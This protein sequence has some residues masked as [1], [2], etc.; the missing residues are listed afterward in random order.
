MTNVAT[1][2]AFFGEDPYT[3]TDTKTV[4]ADQKPSVSLVKS[5]TP[6]TYDQVG[7]LI[8]YTY[9]LTNTGNVTLTDP[10]IADDKATVSYT[11][12]D[13]NA[14]TKP[15]SL[16]PGAKLYGKATYT[17]AQADLDLGA[18]TN[19]ATGK[20][21]FGEDPYTA[22]DTK[23]VNA[24]QMPA[25]SLVKTAT[26]STYDQVGDLISYTYVLTNTGNVTLTRPFDINDD[27]VLDANLTIPAT[28]VSLA[29]NASITITGTYE[30]TADDL[31]AGKVTNVATGT[32]KFG[33]DKVTSNEATATIIAVG[34]LKVFKYYDADHS[35][36]YT[37]GEVG[38][39][40]WKIR[41]YSASRMARWV[42]STRAPHRVRRL[43]DLH[44]RPGR[45]VLGR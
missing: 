3:A 6:S 10:T 37:P 38:I 17:I 40:G 43:L 45:Y 15:D 8:S 22:T 44:Q 25:V 39:P 2:K 35:G 42:P 30:I 1:G 13:G 9:V 16:A 23:T 33:E 31:V 18:V 29:P 27:H 4:N 21:F 5:A 11:D 12:K 28:P 20:A 41:V 34:S 36:S 14:I 19:V 26:P 7:D 32:A 24:D